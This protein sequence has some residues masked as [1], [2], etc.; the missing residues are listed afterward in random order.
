VAFCQYSLAF[1]VFENDSTVIWTCRY[2]SGIEINGLSYPFLNPLDLLDTAHISKFEG[3]LAAA[4][5][6]SGYQGEVSLISFPFSGGY[7]FHIVVTSSDAPDLALTFQF[8]G[9]QYDF[10]QEDCCE[11]N[12]PPPPAGAA[13][14]LLPHN[15][16]LFYEEI[17]YNK[18]DISRIEIGSDCSLG[19]MRNDFSYDTNH[20]VTR[21]LNTFFNPDP[22]AGRYNTS[23]EYD[24]AGNIMK[25]NRYGLIDASAGQYTY[26]LIDSLVYIYANDD[27]RLSSIEDF[28][29]DP[30]AE[31]KG[32][33]IA[34]AFT[35]DGNGNFTSDGDQGLAIASN[36][37]NLPR[38]VASPSDSLLFEYTFGAEKIRKLQTSPVARDRTRLP[39]PHRRPP[40]Q[41]RRVL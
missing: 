10:V 36:L 35:Y 20:R 41:H 32:F 2:A 38:I 26:G 39:I 15:D 21:M 37:I 17:T 22:I 11:K 28:V 5:D 13:A 29:A 8:C 19:Y 31:L 18:L 23:Y 14:G 40:G 24:K 34:G 3:Y 1:S 7:S 9:V 16:D 6:A 25:L 33:K 12:A 4:L 30:L 27:S